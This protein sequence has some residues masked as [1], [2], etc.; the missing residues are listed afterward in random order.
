MDLITSG[1]QRRRQGTAAH[2]AVPDLSGAAGESGPKRGRLAER[3]LSNE[4]SPA[5]PQALGVQQK[6]ETTRKPA[7][8]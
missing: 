7:S 8:R 6:T 4:P 2:V 1:Q 3:R 5:R